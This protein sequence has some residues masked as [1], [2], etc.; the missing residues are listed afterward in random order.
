MPG[1]AGGTGGSPGRER[2]PPAV[3]RGTARG[4]WLPGSALGAPLFFFFF[5]DLC[6]FWFPKS[7][8]QGT[9]AA[10]DDGHGRVL[11]YVQPDLT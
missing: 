4:Q 5:F 1:G 2:T 3:P 11:A 8:R 9:H 10:G 7:P 6:H